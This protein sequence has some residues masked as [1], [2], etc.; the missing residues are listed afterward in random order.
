MKRW[1]RPVAYS[2]VLALLGLAVF[3]GSAPADGADEAIVQPAP[4]RAARDAQA[5]VAIDPVR[6]RRIAWSANLFGVA[7]RPVEAAPPPVEVP[8]TPPAIPDIKVLGWMLSES[9]PHVF[10][11][12]GE[13]SYTLKP[14][15]AV[16]EAYRFDRIDAGFADFTYLP[17]GETRRYT[18]SDPALLE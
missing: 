10:V 12:W 6:E 16:G 14:S 11:A 5:P 9:V 3:G 2:I 8:P 7:P 15:E 17:S 13:E 1:F 18:V 4:Q